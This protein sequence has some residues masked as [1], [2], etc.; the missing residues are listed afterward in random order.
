MK[1]LSIF[2]NMGIF[3][4]LVCAQQ[5]QDTILPL[6]VTLTLDKETYIQG[7][8]LYYE[9]RIDNNT[10]DTMRI[11]KAIDVHYLPKIYKP[12]GEVIPFDWSIPVLINIREEETFELVPGSFYGTKTFWPGNVPAGEYTFH[13]VYCNPIHTGDS[14]THYKFG[15]VRSDTVD[16]IIKDE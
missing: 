4:S 16:L 12:N 9:I 3:A 11:Y 2:V 8:T 13:I 5:P 1:L 6:D 7:E 15:K 14:L 10:P